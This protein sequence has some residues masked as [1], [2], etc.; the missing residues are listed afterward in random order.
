MQCFHGTS[1]FIFCTDILAQ[2][3]CFSCFSCSFRKPDIKKRNIR[4]YLYS[5]LLNGMCAWFSIFHFPFSSRRVAA[6]SYNVYFI[7]GDYSRQAAKAPP[8][9]APAAVVSTLR[10]K[11][12]VRP[13]GEWL[14]LLCW[15]SDTQALVRFFEL[16]SA[17]FFIRYRIKLDIGLNAIMAQIITSIL[18]TDFLEQA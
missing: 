4:C 16:H 5:W 6:M 8:P 14:L 1:A 17:W 9:R 18:S 12:E 7:A 3:T 10:P 15:R 11:S 13:I 2:R